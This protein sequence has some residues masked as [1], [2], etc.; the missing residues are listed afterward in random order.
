M[1]KIKFNVWDKPNQKLIS[2][3]NILKENNLELFI[4]KTK[5]PL[6]FTGIYDKE[7]TELYA[8]DLIQAEIKGTDYIFRIYSA[9]GGFAIKPPHWAKDIRDLGFG[10]ELILEPLL[11]I[12]TSTWVSQSCKKVGNIYEGLKINL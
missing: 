9:P 8:D 11:D 1:N 10:D 6:Q 3:E 7:N 12:Q 5:I 2:W 4:D